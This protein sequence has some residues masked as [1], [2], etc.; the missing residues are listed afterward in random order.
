MSPRLKPRTSG[1]GQC[2]VDE[3]LKCYSG[4]KC[5]SRLM[6]C[7]RMIFKRLA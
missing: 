5:Y 3:Q 4:L 1:G 7:L 6:L 2:S